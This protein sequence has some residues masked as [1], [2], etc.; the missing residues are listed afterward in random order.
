MLQRLQQMLH[1]TFEIRANTLRLDLGRGLRS[2]AERLAQVIDAH[3]QRIVATFL[4]VQHLDA[5]PG[6]P[7]RLCRSAVTVIEQSVEQRRWRLHATAALGQCQRRVFMAHQCAQALVRGTDGRAHVLFAQVQTQRQGIDKDAQ[8]PLGRLGP[9]QT[10]HQHGAEHHTLAT[11]QAR[12][13]PCPTEVK[14]ARDADP[15]R[16]RLRPELLADLRAQRQRVFA[17]TVAI[18][19]QVLQVVSQCRLVQVGQHVAE[20]CF[21]LRLA[22]AQQCLGHVVAKRHRRAERLSLSAQ[23]SLNLVTHHFERAVVHG[24]VVKHQRRLELPIA[25]P[26]I[27]A[28]QTDKRGLPQIERNA[29]AARQGVDHQLRMTPDDLY[30]GFEALPVHRG[31]QN[32]VAGNNGLQR[33]S[34]RVEPLAVGKGEVYVHHIGVTVGGRDMVIQN[35]LLQRSQRIDV[36]HVGRAARY[37]LDQ[38]VNARLI[39]CHQGQHLGGNVVA[40]TWDAVFR[41]GLRATSGGQRIPL[42][43][44]FDQRR[45]VLAQAVQQAFVRQRAAIALHHQLTVLDRQVDVVGLQCRQEFVD[46]HRMISMF[47]VMAA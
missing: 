4:C 28:D 23:A 8:R 25:L 31:A 10:T 24:D 5:L 47:S 14:Q 42:Y 45:F 33:Q 11:G 19:A 9:Q 38:P 22:D 7:G 17:D 41:K 18:T 40:V 3:Y 37:G 44:T 30:R 2:E 35:A 13:H 6:F 29:L 34:K 46:A 32:V 16:T 1:G 12:Q 15:E 20:K 36:L 43:K 26:G 21:V 39:K 27:V